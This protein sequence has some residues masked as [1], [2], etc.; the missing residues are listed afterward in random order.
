MGLE[1]QKSCLEANR[2]MEPE[3]RSSVEAKSSAAASKR[4]ELGPESLLEPQNSL[5]QVVHSCSRVLK[6]R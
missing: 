2:K 5:E 4:M 6:K 3:L 1:Q